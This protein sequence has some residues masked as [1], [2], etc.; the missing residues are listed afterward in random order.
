MAYL[1]VID[2]PRAREIYD[3]MRAPYNSALRPGVQAITPFD[4]WQGLSAYCDNYNCRWVF[5]CVSLCMYPTSAQAVM[6]QTCAK[7][8][9]Q[10][11]PCVANTVV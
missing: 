5:L 11:L 7:T 2:G 1:A 8:V 3:Q 9:P 6:E 10:S 4:E